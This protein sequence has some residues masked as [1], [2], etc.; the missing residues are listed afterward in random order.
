M[1]KR[2][3]NPEN[4]LPVLNNTILE[5]E[6]SSIDRSVGP[7]IL[8]NTK[9]GQIYKA[10][11]VIVTVSLGVLKARHESLFIPTLPKEKITTIQVRLSFLL[12]SIVIYIYI[13]I[14]IKT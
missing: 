11:H 7:A 8:L 5:T 1:Q 3:P 2:Y 13:Y 12:K 14:I 6:V 9:N 4:E 10:D